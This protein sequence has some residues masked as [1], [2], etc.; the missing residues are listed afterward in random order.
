MNKEILQNKNIESVFKMLSAPENNVFNRIL[1]GTGI[2]L[3]GAL[4]C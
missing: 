2:T 3:S 1:W 4:Q